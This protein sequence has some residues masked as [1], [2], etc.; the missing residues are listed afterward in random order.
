MAGPLRIVAV[1]HGQSEANLAY[2]ESMNV[3]LV[4]DRSD[5]E[6]T[7]TELGRRQ[8]AALGR[9][10]GALPEEERPEVVW[11]SPYLRALDTWAVAHAA[12]GADALPV[13]IDARLR[14]REW[15]ELS[16]YN[17]TAIE[18]LFPEEVARLLSDGEYGYRPPGGESF[19]DVAIRLRD[20]LG[21]LRE[22]S[23]GRRVLLVAHDSVVLILRHV[24]EETP[25]ADLAAIEEH[26]PIWN[27]SV[28]TW[29]LTGDR[30]ELVAFNDTG[31]L[32]PG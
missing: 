29:R 31:H 23:D 19:G 11:C 10:L 5:D 8:A 17:L 12:W 13:R 15:G 24:I 4:Y 18:E 25:D 22:L 20:F 26:A 30:L 27:A 1:R 14:D 3:P 32:P 21:D 6:V 7:L 9:A 28:S 2:Q 16:R